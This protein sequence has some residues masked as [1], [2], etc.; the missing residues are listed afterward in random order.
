MIME[1]VKQMKQERGLTNK[2]LSD[3][4]GVPLA[5]INRIM[6]DMKTSPN[7][8]TVCDLVIA[9]GGSLDELAGIASPSEEPIAADA[10]QEQPAPPVQAA[11]E[12]P[13][14]TIR[15]YEALLDERAMEIKTRD[16][17]VRTLFIMCCVLAILLFGIL[18]FDLVNPAIGFFL[19]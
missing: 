5:T 13:M 12:L 4:S 17:W 10:P 6:A 3:L 16:K 14:A 2:Q 8:Q 9:M 11:H 1:K 7:F 18:I 15:A 19:R